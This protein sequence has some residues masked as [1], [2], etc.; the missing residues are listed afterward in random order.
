MGAFPSQSV[1]IFL[2]WLH[3]S[4]AAEYIHRENA[5]LSDIIKQGK[6]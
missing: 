1:N 4:Q 5:T 6:G 3:D 2:G